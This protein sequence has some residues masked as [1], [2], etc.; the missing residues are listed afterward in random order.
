VRQLF[1]S[2]FFH[3]RV[4]IFTF[5]DECTSLEPRILAFCDTF[6]YTCAQK[7]GMHRD[8]DAQRT[9]ALLLFP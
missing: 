2:D 1:F 7:I 4:E 9:L 6:G 8:N 3:C 5:G